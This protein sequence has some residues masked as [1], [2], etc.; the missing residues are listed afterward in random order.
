MKEQL[1]FKAMILNE[2]DNGAKGLTADELAV[3]SGTYSSGS[4][5][6]KVLRDE[7]KEFEQ[8][9]GLVKIVTRIWD[10]ESVVAMVKYS[11]EVDPKK[12]SARN[13]L[14]YL[15]RNRQ[16]EAFNMSSR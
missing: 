5:F 6:R 7:K 2:L 10:N 4:N 13:F 16:F 1:T 15:A 12:K 3:T 14:E 8:F 9:Q 11:E